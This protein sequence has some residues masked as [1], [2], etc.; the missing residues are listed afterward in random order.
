[1]RIGLG[2]LL[3]AAV[4]AAWLVPAALHAGPAYLETMVLKQNVTRYAD[5]WHHFQP[6]WYYLWV[7]PA[8]YFPWS[9][10]LPT[11]LVVG[12]RRL[13]TSEEGRARQG[14][15]FALCWML[16]TLAFFS[17]SPAKRT[18]Y[19]LTMY[20]AMALLVGAALDRMAADWRGLGKGARRALVWP[21]GLVAAFG[22]L[23]AAA[24][25]VAAPLH[26]A[27]LMPLG[28]G[29]VAEVVAG[30]ALLAAGAL[31]AWWLARRGRVT[32][33]AGALAGGTAALALL[34]F[35]LAV[36]RLDSVKSARPLS[37]LLVERMGSGEPYAVFPR[38]DAAF[39]YYTGRYSVP[40]QGEAELREFV[41]RPGRKWLLI[42]RDDLARVQES[43][44]VLPLVEVA[45]DRDPREGYLL[46]TDP[47]APPVGEEPA[48]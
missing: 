20:P 5:P 48:R 42:E 37:E 17:L 34:L 28:P 21:L 4:V 13:R 38:L 18:V 27:D 31:A 39:L 30:F 9:A 1:M 33:A 2:L 25:P 3:W 45:R 26:A 24:L 35:L 16:V 11:A 6:P 12:W 19:I 46:M 14:Y 15:L 29:L 7:L 47:P 44:G 36:P 8:D 41:R 43:G 22:L 32:A 40:V 10:L 23:V